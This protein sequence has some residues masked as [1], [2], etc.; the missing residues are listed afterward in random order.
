M[1]LYDC[2]LMA[3]K[4]ITTALKRFSEGKESAFLF[5]FDVASA[6]V[7]SLITPRFGENR[8]LSEYL[9]TLAMDRLLGIWWSDAALYEWSEEVFMQRVRDAVEGVI[10]DYEALLDRHYPSSDAVLIDQDYAS[11]LKLK[12]KAKFQ[13]KKAQNPNFLAYYWEHFRFYF[14]GA[15][16]VVG[17]GFFLLLFGFVS[18]NKA[19]SIFA[20]AKILTMT[21]NMAFGRLDFDQSE[22]NEQSMTGISM[23]SQESVRYRIGKGQLPSWNKEYYV[24]KEQS[25]TEISP[26][27]L[28]KNLNL[29]AIRWSNLQQ[30]QLSS[31]VLM[32]GDVEI[33]LDLGARKLSFV[34]PTLPAKKSEF[35]T[36]ESAIKKKVRSQISAFGLSLEQYGVARI[37]EEF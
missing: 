27:P 35:V 13:L 37:Q 4:T 9:H 1:F 20:N 3:E 19:P 31:L 18:I 30:S 26:I 25:K 2:I 17:I 24:L 33:S 12:L 21:G 6:E 32:S 22:G 34:D 36:S 8:K 29:P 23:W 7:W 28:L 16:V 15:C 14:T 10:G 5:L 11:Q